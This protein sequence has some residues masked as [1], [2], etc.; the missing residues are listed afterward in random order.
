[1]SKHI[2]GKVH[3]LLLSEYNVSTVLG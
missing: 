3:N 2:F 1:M